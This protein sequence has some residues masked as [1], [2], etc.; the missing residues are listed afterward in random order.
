MFQGLSVDH[1]AYA[2]L[3]FCSWDI[4]WR[5][6]LLRQMESHPRVEDAAIPPLPDQTI[7]LVTR[8]GGE[9]ESASGGRWTRTTYRVGQ[10]RM[11][12]PHRPARLRWRA[13]P[14]VPH[15]TLHL[16][17]PAAMIARVVEDVWDR[18]PERVMLPDTLATQD[19][20]LERVMLDL[21]RAAEAGVGDF[22]AE[23]AAL[24]LAVHTLTRHGGLPPPR[25][26]TGEDQRIQ[27]ARSFLRQNLHQP[28]SLAEIAAEASM[29]PYHFLRVFRDRTGETPYRYLTRLRIERGQQELAR[30]A[31]PVGEIADRCGFASP[32]H[33]ANAFR[34]QT[35]YTPTQYRRRHDH[36]AN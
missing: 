8:G 32:T 30:G 24:F 36:P 28:L 4:G 12:A 3:L 29:S 33:F 6:L 21:L 10:I 19:P 17:L 5:S 23:A 35:G 9:V 25:P 26:S 2:D 22:Y 31:V 7:V 13:D 20:L 34:R 16:H 11:T 18:D 14:P 15:R 1:H 27:H